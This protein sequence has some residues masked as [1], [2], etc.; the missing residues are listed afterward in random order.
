MPTRSGSEYI[1]KIDNLHSSIWIDGQKVNGKISEHQAFKGVMKSQA[2]LYD[3]QL[4]E[5][6]RDIMTFRSPVTGNLVG[7]SFLEPKTKKDLEK[8]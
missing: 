4:K 6:N 1:E 7:T 2:A 8:N 5:S 3:L